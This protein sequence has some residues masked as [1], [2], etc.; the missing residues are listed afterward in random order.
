MKL[1]KVNLLI[2]FCI[3]GMGY[4]LKSQEKKDDV[5]LTIANK[6]ITVEEFMAIYQKNN[7]KGTA[8]DKKNLDEYLQ[9][10][11]NFKLKVKQAEDLGLDTVTS[12]KTELSGYRDQLA[13]PYFTDEET[14]EWLIKQAYEREHFDIRAS[15][16]FLKLKPDA[17]PED[18]LAAY[19]KIQKIR[20]RLMNGESF[21]KLVLEF[22]EDPSAK[23]RDASQGRPFMRGNHGDLGY[24][25]VF[26]ML[27]PF[28]NAAYTTAVGQV[29]PPVRTE[30]GYHLI[31]VTDKRDAMGKVTVAHIF[32]LIPKNATHADSLAVKARIDTAYNKLRAGAKWDD[33]VKQ[34]SDDKGSAAKGGVLPKF[35]VNRMVPE[36]IVSI[37]SLKNDGDYSEPVMT[38]YGWHIIKLIDRKGPGT[39]DEEKADLKQKVTKDS[40]SQLARDAVY[41]RIKKENGFTEYPEARNDFYNVVTDSI[42]AGHWDPALAKDLNKPMFKLGTVTYKQ[43]EFTDYLAGKQKKRDKENIRYY[44]NQMYADFVDDGLIKWENAHLEQKYPEFRALMEEYRDGILLF[45]LTDQKVWS[46]AVKD[47][48]GLKD[49]YEKNKKN[50]MWE[51]RVQASIYTVKD[52]S[53]VQKVK[54]FIKSGLAD[55]DI[56]KEM[57]TDSVK[58]LAIESG[59][60]SR[61]DN[62]YIDQVTWTPG[63]SNDIKADSSVVFVNIVK[64]MSPEPKA[65][66]EA[67]GLI[68]ADYQNYLEKIWIESLR[69][70]YPVVVH[71]DVLAQIK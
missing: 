54:N 43:R 38:P 52:P 53:K 44:V 8:V 1:L 45:D 21:E 10:F 46:K 18:T 13:K 37:Y 60:F 66:N 68:T 50:Y 51:A 11:I 22:S 49:F 59:K 62:K 19:Q 31:K 69:K 64:L 26:D 58:V 16:I 17:M 65:L 4:S 9:L 40:R 47:T 63:I 5:L 36:F 12:F 67:R 23:D 20:E 28:E 34:Y 2:I 7:P 56:L 41:A 25:T 39:F 32:K 6:K 29:S 33:I 55:A 24:F 48:T 71:E 42:F 27:Y 61:K 30:Y 35:G 3:I 70:Q 57:N 14:M 15:H